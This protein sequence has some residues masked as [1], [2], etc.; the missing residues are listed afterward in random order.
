MNDKEIV[1]K[2]IDPIGSV[3]MKTYDYVVRV[4]A[5][6]TTKASVKLATIEA[7][8]ACTASGTGVGKTLTADAV[9]VLTVDSVATVLNDR[10]LVKNQATAK[11][12]GIYEVTTE[13]TTAVAFVL[14]RATDVD[15]NAEAL[16]GIYIPV[17]AGTE[18][19]NTDYTLSTA[20]PIVVDTTSLTFVL[21]V[22]DFTI[23][24][25]LVAEAKG[26][27][28][29]IA[30]NIVTAVNVITIA[31]KGDSE[32]WTDL[33]LDTSGDCALLYSDGRKWWNIGGTI[34]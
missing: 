1:D 12:N 16:S 7:L 11:D 14:T 19:A 26:C 29:S 25:P 34:A 18:N 30:G 27:I 5:G 33:T 8:P 22:S 23:T 3:Q 6:I 2:F 4:F 9:G 17:T 28:Y 15:E 31:H 10:I 20:D 24:L 13:G 21:A 32:G